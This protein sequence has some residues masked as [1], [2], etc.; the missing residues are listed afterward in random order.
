MSFIRNMYKIVR[1]FSGK[2][3]MRMICIIHYPFHALLDCIIHLIHYSPTSPHFPPPYPQTLLITSSSKLYKVSEICSS[4]LQSHIHTNN[5][6][7][8]NWLW[9]YFRTGYNLHPIPIFV[10][11][12]TYSHA[13]HTCVT[14]QLAIC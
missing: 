9:T 10:L 13:F 11:C 6:Y 7:I 1:G 3:R 14:Y 12:S 8:A 2:K 5:L 4:R